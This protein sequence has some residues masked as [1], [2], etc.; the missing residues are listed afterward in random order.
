MKSKRRG[1]S[2]NKRIRRTK[3]VSTPK[4][5]SALMEAVSTPPKAVSTPLETTWFGSRKK[6]QP[7]F[8]L[9]NV[10]GLTGRLMHLFH[11]LRFSRQVGGKFVVIW[12]PPNE[13]RSH[14]DDPS[15]YRLEDIFDLD[16]YR[17]EF[18]DDFVVYTGW[19]EPAETWVN[20]EGPQF[21][22]IRPNNFD[23]DYFG[24]GVEAYAV[25]YGFNQFSDEKKTN[26]QITSEVND[27]FW[28]MPT[29]LAV[30]EALKRAQD[31]LGSEPFVAIDVRRRDITVPMKNA[32]E[33]FA[34]GGMPLDQFRR[35]VSN[36]VASVAPPAAYFPEVAA[37]VAAKRKI[38][39]SADVPDAIV[40]FEEH[41]G[42][43]HFVDLAT[44][45]DVAHPAQKAFCD[46]CTMSKAAEVMST[47]SMF[48]RMATIFGNSRS[49]NV[50]L[51]VSVEELERFTIDLLASH[52]ADERKLRD[53]LLAE[54]A[55]A[56]EARKVGREGKL[57]DLRTWM[58]A[59]RAN[60]K[61]GD[62]DQAISRIE[63]A[64]SAIGSTADVALADL[65]VQALLETGRL[66]GLENAILAA[67]RRNLEKALSLTYKLSADV[68][69]AIMR[70]VVHRL[71]LECD[72]SGSLGIR[73]VRFLV[74][75]IERRLATKQTEG[76]DNAVSEL[77]KQIRNP[78][79]SPL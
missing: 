56:Y 19:R 59:I 47:A 70:R 79:T 8:Y 9:A 24:R 31:R 50:T 18:G 11:G 68:D 40:P 3:R 38:V 14:F 66:A 45:V 43:E 12:S 78:V 32:L 73:N 61:V 52:L 69:P 34:R 42:P 1:A 26:T 6:D 33:G 62:W 30:Q 29:T 67:G 27:L 25:R 64:V 35:V 57:K 28:S 39:F 76:D 74:N 7:T 15:S 54:M 51:S 48:A 53:T 65:R 22:Q 23:R 71:H 10:S 44:L 77:F 5:A 2:S 63:M 20:L 75:M 55:A 13:T 49:I 4:T 41:F 58:P 72:L 17:T 37:A 36:F 60:M 21:G 16:K 46:F